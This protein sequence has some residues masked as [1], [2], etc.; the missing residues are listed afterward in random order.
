MNIFFIYFLCFWILFWRAISGE[1]MYGLFLCLILYIA[2]YLRNKYS[3]ADFGKFV[4]V[5]K[6]SYFQFFYVIFK[7]LYT[8]LEKLKLGSLV[9][10]DKVFP[11]TL[12]VEWRKSVGKHF[13][14][15]TLNVTDCEN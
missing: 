7:I 2:I 8:N 4:P 12:N 1:V 3:W 9:I 13:R 5:F 6:I 10:E 15:R 11:Y 14:N